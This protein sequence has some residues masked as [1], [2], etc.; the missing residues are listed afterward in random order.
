MLME[1]ERK[2]VRGG[3]RRKGYDGGS[4]RGREGGRV[5]RRVRQ[6]R[7]EEGRTICY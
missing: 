7:E 3:E 2:L 4:V 6:K 5:R 1:E